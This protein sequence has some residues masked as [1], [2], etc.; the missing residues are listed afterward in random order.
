MDMVPFQ[1]STNP[2]KFTTIWKEDHGLARTI[3]ESIYI[4][5]NNPALNRNVD[6]YNLHYIWDRG[7]FSTPELRISND[8]GHVHVT[9]IR[10]ILSP[11]QPIG[12]CIEQQGILGM[13]SNRIIKTS[14]VHQQ[15]QHP[16]QELKEL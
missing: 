11:F 13:L 7:L 5:V 15:H 1:D 16:I 14:I 10:G 6:K 12:M 9:P 4:R 8:N 2:H 3:K